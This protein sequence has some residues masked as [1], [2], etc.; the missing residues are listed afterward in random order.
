MPPNALYQ[1]LVEALESQLAPRV[2][3][4]VLREGMAPGGATP[5]TLT[6]DTVEAVL[7]GPVFRQLQT[8]GRAVS[9]A[10]ELVRELENYV[11]GTIETGTETQA[12]GAADSTGTDTV[13]AIGAS[14]APTLTPTP[15]ARATDDPVR[16]ALSELQTAL[17]PF[18][19]YFSWPE[20][21]K[22]RSLVQVA[23]DEFARGV[24]AS[25][26]VTEAEAQ[27]QLVH[28]KLEDQ[29]VLQARTLADLESA[30]EVVAPLGTAGVRRLDALIATVRDAQARRTLVEAETERAEKLAR[31]LRKLVESTILDEH[32]PLPDLGRGDGRPRAPTLVPIDG[33]DPLPGVPT[34]RDH[35]A[36]IAAAGA[37]V[38]GA[39][40]DASAAGDA[41]AAADARDRLHALDLEGEARDLDALAARHAELVRHEPALAAALDELRAEHR[42]GRVLGERLAQLERDWATQCEARRQTLR[43]EFEAIRAETE[44]LPP[45]VDT[46]DL[47]HAL[48]VALDLLEQTLPA[49]EDIATVRELHATALAQSERLERERRERSVRWQEQR[50]QIAAVRGRLDAAWRETR[51]EP[52]LRRAREHLHEV[53]ATLHEDAVTEEHG[54]ILLEA[55]LDAEAAWQ[56]SVAEASD[57]QTARQLALVR[58]MSA[59]LAQLP[60][61]PGLRARTMAVRAEVEALDAVD[62]ID[63]ARLHALT[64]LVEQLSGDARAAVARRL[65]EIAREAG[66][67]A[68]EALL[69]VLQAAARQFDEGGFPDLDEVE[70]EVALTHDAR[71]AALRRRY[72]RAR[73]E[74][75]RL[76]DAG[77]PS[78]DGLMDLV[79]AAREAVD[80]DVDAAAAIDDLERRAGEVEREV[81]ARLAGFA[82]RLD[83]ALSA[84]QKVA[85]L[86]NDDVAAVRRVL[87][88]LDDQRDA[89]G[90]VSPGLQ[91][92]LFA[93]LIEAEGTLRHLEAAFEATRAVAD[94]LVSGGRLD[95]LLGA[96]DGLF[97][98]RAAEPQRGRAAGAPAQGPEVEAWLD[99]YLGADDVAGAILLNPAG[100]LLAGRV[101]AD[102]DVVAVGATLGATLEAWGAL[103]E[104]MGDEAPDLAQIEIGGRPTWLAP[105]GDQGCA[106]VW[107]RR[108][109][110]STSLGARL[111][112]DRRELVGMLRGPG[113]AD[114][115]TGAPDAAT[116]EG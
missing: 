82:A 88:H 108:A 86:N 81:A 38:D 24:D 42:A 64:H 5:D 72:L 84:F 74:A 68:P 62:V 53:L 26:V 100:R 79:S 65:D 2:V 29:L 14:H 46:V 17:R 56:R 114:P 47:R 91:A 36:V 3:S 102:V 96:F 19:L 95:D 89:V 63:D 13:D 75:Q 37:T 98:A 78:A 109:A 18:N 27:L 110:P 48:I 59:R 34:G 9:A 7:R 39:A 77:V 85:R 15:V 8:T 76:A 106:L 40:V 54:A 1:T 66:E 104:R 32:D 22:L 4:R 20:V 115:P 51:G 6:M 49:V 61:I 73:Q 30:F 71:R 43:T 25:V 97:E 57:D 11:R 116:A 60:D 31:E 93:S 113:D 101:P 99:R 87:M 58:A 28:Q 44:A 10:R 23:E 107:S 55:A 70:R 80:A 103:G 111:R 45:S 92:Q 112:D 94:Q 41:S 67:P 90:R 12:G 33:R 83:A 69:R 50:S 21:R 16:I 52:R 105:L 35:D